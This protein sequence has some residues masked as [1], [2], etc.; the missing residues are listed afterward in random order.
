MHF[1]FPRRGL[2][3]S[4]IPI[5]SPRNFLKSSL[6][7][8]PSLALRSARV[9]SVHVTGGEQPPERE[10]SKKMDTNVLEEIEKLRRASLAELQGRYR[11]VF[12]ED[13]ASRHREHL[14]RKI[15]WR[16]Q[17]LHEGDLSERARARA[18]ELACD[19]DLRIVAPRGFFGDRPSA[20]LTVPRTD[21]GGNQ[22]RRLPIAGTL[23]ERRY[24]GKAHFVEVL[25]DGFRYEGRHHRSLSS[26]AREITGTR[27]NGSGLLRFRQRRGYK[28]RDKHRRRATMQLESKPSANAFLRCA[29][30]TRKV[31]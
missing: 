1:F 8:L 22:D 5:A 2:R 24:R 23:I 15:A 3:L 31:D 17:A 14:F 16:V 18:R 19:A 28:A 11:E 4:P 30:Y 20:R 25:P 27:W 10:K 21:R 12:G 26:V 29:I 9:K 6:L 13:T 7:F